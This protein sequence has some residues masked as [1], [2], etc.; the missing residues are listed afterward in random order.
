MA[1]DGS[2]AKRAAGRARLCS[3]EHGLHFG[4]RGVALRRLRSRFETMMMMMNEDA[5]PAQV[6]GGDL[7][8]VPH[9]PCIDCGAKTYLWCESRNAWH[10][11]GCDADC[12]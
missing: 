5:N 8:D 2:T 7:E 1:R 9:G 10:C 4:T 3:R 12:P 6:A 11:T